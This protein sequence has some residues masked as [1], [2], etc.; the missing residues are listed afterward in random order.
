MTGVIAMVIS[1]SA[2]SEIINKRIFQ[3]GVYGDKKFKN[4][5][6]GLITVESS[7]RL[8]IR[9]R[10][11]PSFYQTNIFIS[12]APRRGSR[13][14]VLGVVTPCSLPPKGFFSTNL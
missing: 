2:F 12:K 10:W 6:F 1:K 5:M 7:E 13:G 11:R 3:A 8:Q 4:G 14:G 9:P